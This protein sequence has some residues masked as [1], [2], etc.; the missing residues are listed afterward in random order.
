MKK[1]L[2]IKHM[3]NALTKRENIS[4]SRLKKLLNIHLIDR[5][6]YVI[7]EQ[8]IDTKLKWVDEETASG[9]LSSFYRNSVQIKKNEM[10][11][12]TLYMSCDMKPDN[13]EHV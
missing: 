3:L 5:T 13:N 4:I 11:L 12:N 6:I 7:L 8:L 2:K 9:V 10:H 1:V